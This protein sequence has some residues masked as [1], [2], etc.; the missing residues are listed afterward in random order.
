MSK[1]GRAGFALRVLFVDTESIETA[2]LYQDLFAKAQE[3]YPTYEFASLPL[4]HIFDLVAAEDDLF[5]LLPTSMPKD[6]SSGDKLEQ[7]LASLNSATARADV[8]S[9]LRTKLIV[10]HAKSTGCEGVLWGDSTTKLAEKTLAETAKGRGFSLP[11]QVADGESPFGLTFNY[12]L[13]DLLKKELVSYTDINGPPLSTIVRE[14]LPTQASISS[15]NTTID[16]L[17]KQYFE[18][19]EENF[20]SIVSNVVRTTGKLEATPVSGLTPICSLCSMP[21]SDSRFG[22]S[23]WGGDQQTSAEDAGRKTAR[24]CYGC[25]RSMPHPTTVTATD[26]NG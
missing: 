13:R 4:D 20:P 8:V 6:S 12:P 15:K 2:P 11:W 5:T 23:G 26:R 14:S 7:L 22:I 25:T 24:L 9:T 1:T 18:S 17:M 16:D 3:A 10:E 21:V 19:V